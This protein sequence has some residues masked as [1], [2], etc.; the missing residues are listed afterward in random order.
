MY[1][2]CTE[3]S[4]KDDILKGFTNGSTLRIVITTVAFGMGVDCMAV[5]QVIHLGP[6]F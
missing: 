4:V 3:Q 6:F 5:R 1:M 2:S